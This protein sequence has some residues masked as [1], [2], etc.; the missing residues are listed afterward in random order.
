[1]LSLILG[2]FARI[3]SNSYL[4]VFQKL[5]TNRGEYSSIVNLYTYL[6]LSIIALIFCNSPIFNPNIMSYVLVMGF[7][8]ALGNCFIVKA[9]SY[10]ELS[11]LAPINSYKPIVA[12]IIGF[13]VLQEVPNIISILGIIFI[14]LGTFILGN[15]TVIFNKATFYRFIAL[16]LLGTEAIFIKK[17][18]L[19]TDVSSA[20]LYW[21]LTGFIFSLFF[22]LF[23][24]HNLKI[25]KQNIKYQLILIFLVAIMQYT[26]NYVF[27]KMNVAYALALFQLSTIISVFL[28]VNIFKE[29]G[30]AKKILASLIMIVGAVLIIVKDL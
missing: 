23:S 27:S 12:L 18:I 16:I 9:L 26:T 4:N 21:V 14:I 1:M 17:V 5:L 29:K 30:L 2:I 13:I 6:G 15:S 24:K 20:F 19:L 11:A 10:G 25:K 28:G 7:L 8:G 3:I 22:V